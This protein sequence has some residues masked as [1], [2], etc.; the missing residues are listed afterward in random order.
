M[1]DFKKSISIL[2][3]F[4]AHMDCEYMEIYLEQIR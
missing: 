4:V 2:H 3:S 1:E